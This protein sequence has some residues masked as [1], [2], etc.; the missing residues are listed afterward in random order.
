M[1]C[2]MHLGRSGGVF[3]SETNIIH[4]VFSG[5]DV[6][7]KWWL[8]C[9]LLHPTTKHLNRL[10]AILVN[11]RSSIKTMADCWQLTQCRSVIKPKTD[12]TVNQQSWE[13]PVQNYLSAKN[14]RSAWYEKG[15]WIYRDFKKSTGWIF[16]IIGWLCTYT[17]KTHFSSNNM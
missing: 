10:G 1:I 11:N 4:Y 17:V 7:S 14:L 15:V 3:P 13:G 5:S 16:I 9:S 6:W 2:A 12:A 8:L